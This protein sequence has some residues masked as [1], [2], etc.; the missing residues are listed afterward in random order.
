MFS[1]FIILSSWGIIIIDISRVVTWPLTEQLAKMIQ[2]VK[3]ICLELKDNFVCR[4]TL[5]CYTLYS[6]Q[7]QYTKYITDSGSDL[8]MNAKK[9]HLISI[10]FPLWICSHLCFCS[11]SE[12]LSVCLRANINSFKLRIEHSNSSF[13]RWLLLLRSCQVM[14]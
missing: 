4:T 11:P 10:G 8:H 12:W 3:K 14:L 1:G 9:C 7:N 5:E 6:P 2:N 13:S